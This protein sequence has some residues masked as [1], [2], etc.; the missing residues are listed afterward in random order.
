MEIACPV[1]P[2][3]VSTSASDLHQK[4]RPFPSAGARVHLPRPAKNDSRT[5]VTGGAGMRSYIDLDS[6]SRPSWDTREPE[7]FGR[8]VNEDLRQ[9][10]VRTREVPTIAPHMVKA[11]AR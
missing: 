9:A 5:L 3:F 6:S 11:R 2:K 1:L 4:Y 7:P 10:V 8:C